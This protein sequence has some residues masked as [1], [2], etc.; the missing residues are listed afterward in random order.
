M[1]VAPRRL[2][3]DSHDRP[4]AQPFHELAMPFRVV[5]ELEAFP[6]RTDVDVELLLAHVDADEQIG[7]L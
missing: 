5:V 2:E 7:L 6:E 1:F 3:D 4:T